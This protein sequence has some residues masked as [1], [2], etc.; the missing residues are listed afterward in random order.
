[1]SH[2]FKWVPLKMSVFVEVYVHPRL[3]VCVCIRLKP[4][5][6]S[7][8]RNWRS[9]VV[10]RGADWETAPGHLEALPL[11]LYLVFVFTCACAR[12]CRSEFVFTYVRSSALCPPALCRTAVSSRSSVAGEK[13][14][15]R[16]KKKSSERID[17]EALKDCGALGI[18]ARRRS[19]KL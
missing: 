2:G 12:T 6:S 10:P 8:C 15:K 9:L 3:C 14:K 7:H 4:T 5:Q 13:K 17:E 16:E 11:L 18:A 1:M 19:S